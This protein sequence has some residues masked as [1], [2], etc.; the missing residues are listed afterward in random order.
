MNGRS[1]LPARFRH[2]AGYLRRHDPDLRIRPSVERPGFFVLER[3]CRRA[4]AVNTA[5][6]DRSDLH[7]QARDGYI[8]ISLAHVNWLRHPWNIIRALRD[9]GIDL[10]AAGGVQ[11]VADELAYEE[12]WLK[13]SRRRRRKEEFYNIAKEAYDVLSRMG[14]HDGTDVSRFNNAGHPAVAPAAP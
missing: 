8:H 13:E 4:P 7:V 2:V 3:R 12:Q 1:T 5:M 10:W 14:N 9:S 6:R 11:T